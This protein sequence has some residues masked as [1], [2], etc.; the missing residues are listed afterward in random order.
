MIRVQKSTFLHCL[1]WPVRLVPVSSFVTRCGGPCPPF[2]PHFTVKF[3]QGEPFRP[4]EQ[5]LGVL[6]SASARL[7]P[8]P[9][10]VWKV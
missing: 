5:L 7:L 10:Q 1:A 8:S 6:P 4:F 9:F 3:T 2:P